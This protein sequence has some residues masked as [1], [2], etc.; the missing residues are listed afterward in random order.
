MPPMSGKLA[1]A[2]RA[3]LGRRQLERAEGLINFFLPGSPSVRLT[4]E[5]EDDDDDDDATSEVEERSEIYDIGNCNESG[6]PSASGRRVAC[7]HRTN[8]EVRWLFTA[9]YVSNEAYTEKE[10]E[11][12]GGGDR[13][14]A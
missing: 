6:R 11:F 14:F 9:C 10:E 5:R 12:R 3:A 2:G 13:S 4:M 8:E 1:V 7:G